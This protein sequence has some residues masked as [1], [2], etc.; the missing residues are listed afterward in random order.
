M[1]FE[2]PYN[3]GHYATDL[4]RLCKLYNVTET[5]SGSYTVQ[6]QSG[7]FFSLEFYE[8]PQLTPDADRSD[9]PLSVGR[10]E[11]AES[12]PAASV[13]PVTYDAYQ[14]W[15]PTVVDTHGF[16]TGQHLTPSASSSGPSKKRNSPEAG[17]IT[18]IHTITMPGK[19]APLVD[20]SYR[21]A[22]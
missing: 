2:L 22:P 18:G 4:A 14:T 13:E 10:R 15:S 8:Q 7:N 3:D 5:S 19:A 21:I 12:P 17:V 6:G 9:F 1:L 16:G 11:D 20:F